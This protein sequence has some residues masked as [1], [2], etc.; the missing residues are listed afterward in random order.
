[1]DAFAS[2]LLEGKKDKK[3]AETVFGRADE[4]YVENTGKD[5]NL[6]ES[7][8]ACKHALNALAACGYIEYD[9]TD[10]TILTRP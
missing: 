9:G 10:I 3:A 7:A 8:W 1:M 4:L 5:S 2:A 6:R